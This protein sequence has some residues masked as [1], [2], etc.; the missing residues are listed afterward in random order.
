MPTKIKSARGALRSY[1][2]YLQVMHRAGQFCTDPIGKCLREKFAVNGEPEKDIQFCVR[3]SDTF[4]ACLRGERLWDNFR[5]DRAQQGWLIW[6][7]NFSHNE[8]IDPVEV[9]VDWSSGFFREVETGCFGCVSDVLNCLY[10]SRSRKDFLRPP[11]E[12]LAPGNYQEADADLETHRFELEQEEP[13]TRQALIQA[14]RGLGVFREQLIFVWAGIC[15][16]TKCRALPILR[17]SHIKPWREC[18]NAERLDR[19][20]GL[21]LSPNLDAAFDRGLISFSDQGAILISK[22]LSA[23]DANAIG[24]TPDLRLACVFDENK[25]FLALHRQLHGF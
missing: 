2:D 11:A 16:V 14:R 5:Q 21:L 3:D 9:A 22:T 15:A 18:T 24:I 19:F 10:D 23:T 1:D 7:E 17:A 20:N 12:S 13:T 25:P 8:L 4:A 6:V